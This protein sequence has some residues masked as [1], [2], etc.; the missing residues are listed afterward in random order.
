MEVLEEAGLDWVTERGPALAASLADALA[1]SGVQVASR[2]A[3]TLVSWAAG[4]CEAE[5]AR[6]ADAGISV[7]AI[8]DRGLVRASVGAW[9]SDEELDRLARTAG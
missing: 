7:R 3:S 5:V 2:G 8:A 1:A 6:L 9:S 4:D